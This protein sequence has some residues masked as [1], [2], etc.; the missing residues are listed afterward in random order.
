MPVQNPVIRFPPVEAADEEGLLAMGGNLEPAT[1]LEA[2]RNGIFPWFN[3][4]DPILWWSPD[5]RCV[6]FPKKL[7]VHASMKS[8]LRSQRFRYTTNQAFETVM[9]HCATAPRKGQSGTWISE[10]MVKAYTQLHRLGYAHSAE[11]WSG[12]ELAGG[13]YGV[14]IGKVFFGESMFSRVSNASKY[15]FIRFVEERRASGITLID[16]QQHTA[17]LESRG[18]ELI[19][20]KDFVELLRKHCGSI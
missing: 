6:L 15:A 12:D 7:K 18:A 14:Q 3:A 9:R 8:I 11:A 19:S 2:Y 20:R 17:L 4:G 1:L 10:E 13:L 16:C 5:P